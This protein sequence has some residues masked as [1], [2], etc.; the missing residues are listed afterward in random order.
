MLFESMLKEASRIIDGN[1]SLEEMDCYLREIIENGRSDTFNVH[2][3]FLDD[4]FLGKK[5]IA[6]WSRR[7]C[8]EQKLSVLFTK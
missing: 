4:I 1:S 5:V 8:G 7:L 3:V 2:A 6:H